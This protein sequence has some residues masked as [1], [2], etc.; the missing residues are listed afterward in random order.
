MALDNHL[1]LEQKMHSPVS[2]QSGDSIQAFRL[3]TAIFSERSDAELEEKRKSPA[4]TA[5]L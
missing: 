4:E 1:I 5:G 3:K 2:G